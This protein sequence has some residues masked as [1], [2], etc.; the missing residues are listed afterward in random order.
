MD[1]LC[2]FSM[3]ILYGDDLWGRPMGMICG[4]SLSA[5]AKFSA[6]GCTNG[7]LAARAEHG[8]GEG[9]RKCA[10]VQVP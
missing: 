9:G 1:C 10:A 5:C 3:R 6:Q 2:L 7:I 8:L 4:D